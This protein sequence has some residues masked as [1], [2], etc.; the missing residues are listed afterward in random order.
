MPWP[1]DRAEGFVP[2][3]DDRAEG[4]VPPQA[5]TEAQKVDPAG[6][7]TPVQLTQHLLSRGLISPHEI[8]DRFRITGQAR[9]NRNFAVVVSPRRGYFV[10]ESRNGLEWLAAEADVY[11][12]IAACGAAGRLRHHLPRFRDYDDDRRVLVLDLI[13]GAAGMWGSFAARR[14]IALRAAAELGRAVAAVHACRIESERLR[15]AGVPWVLSLPA[16]DIEFLLDTG[17]ANVELLRIVQSSRILCR[18]LERLSLEWTPLSLIH[19][20]LRFANCV[21]DRRAR[22]TSVKLVDWEL[23]GSGDPAWDIGCVFAE[24]LASWIDSMPLSRL[25]PPMQ[26]FAGTYASARRLGGRDRRNF[27][28]RAMRF[29]AARLL[30]TAFEGMRDLGGLT[31]DAVRMLQ[32]S[33]NIAAR[34]SKALVTLC[35]IDVGR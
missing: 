29:S 27:L 23:A 6:V 9:N 21:V 31:K 8:G 3:A 11:R 15:A 20:D 26:Q 30:Q 19:G 22:H 25:K 5:G 34:P 18:T 32:L 16:P 2:A 12:A 7:L 1:D 35:G 24:F 17:P 28:L 14:P 33:A 13:P 10:K 4:F